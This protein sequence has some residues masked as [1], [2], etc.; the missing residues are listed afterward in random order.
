MTRYVANRTAVVRGWT[1]DSLDDY[2]VAQIP[3]GR[4]ASPE[5]IAEVIED[6]L[7]SNVYL[8]G[9]IIPVNGAR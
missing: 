7:N 2:M 3:M 8:N 9:A 5:E 6:V 4:P 1:E